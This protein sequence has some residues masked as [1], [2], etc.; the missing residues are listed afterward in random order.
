[1]KETPIQCVCIH[2]KDAVDLVSRGASKAR[3]VLQQTLVQRT[4]ANVAARITGTEKPEEILTL[5]AHAP[6][7]PWSRCL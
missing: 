5:T 6:F 2:H 7:L 4:S 1:M 3:L